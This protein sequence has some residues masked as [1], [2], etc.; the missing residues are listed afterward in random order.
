MRFDDEG[1][2]VVTPREIAEAAEQ[3]D[4]SYV[5][6]AVLIPGTPRA[7]PTYNQ[8]HRLLRHIA[9]NMGIHPSNMFFRGST[10]IGFSIAPRAEKVW[11]QFGPA[12]DLDLAIVD[13][14]TFQILD[15]EIMQWEWNPDNRRTMFFANSMQ[16]ERYKN[17]AHHKGRFDCFRYFD[18]PPV[19][20]T[21]R[22]SDC[23][24]S[25]PVAECCGTN[26]PLNAFVFRDWWGVCKKYDY[27][28]DQLRRGLR[29]VENPLPVGLDDPRPYEE[30]AE[31]LPD[32]IETLSEE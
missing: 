29:R 23:L 19:N 2:L 5:I 16:L 1:H 18:L 4:F 10:K 17:R 7:I 15:H 8:Y 28:L 26:R 31:L 14:T 3:R 21:E 11:M 22:L 24:K 20:C 6:N 25:A 30:S 13:A 12:A 32:D 27:D 9:D